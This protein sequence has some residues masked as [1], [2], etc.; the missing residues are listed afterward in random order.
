MPYR[1][2][3]NDLK[4]FDPGLHLGFSYSQASVRDQSDW[5][6]A[7]FPEE[8][9]MSGC[10]VWS[11]YSLDKPIS[12]EPEE[13]RLVGIFMSSYPDSDVLKAV[14]LRPLLSFLQKLNF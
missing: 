11:A 5:Q 2:D 8:R 7:R 12:F 3:T 13:L 10:G 4:N 14:A 6:I 9:G 1:G